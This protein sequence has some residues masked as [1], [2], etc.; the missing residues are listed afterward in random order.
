MK[1]RAH[2]LDLVDLRNL[3]RSD[4]VLL[5]FV[6]IIAFPERNSRAS[7]PVRTTLRN[8]SIL[9]HRASA[10]TDRSQKVAVLVEWKTTGKDDK[11]S[12][13]LFQSC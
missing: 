1:N 6:S 11:P 12:V 9:F 8:L 5:I 7:E 4:S 3:S 10:Y 13:G 2:L